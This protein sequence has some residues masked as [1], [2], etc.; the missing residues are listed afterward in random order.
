MSQRRKWSLALP[1]LN[2]REFFPRCLV[3]R[4]HGTIGRT[5][6][7]FVLTTYLWLGLLPVSIDVFC[8]SNSQH[9]AARQERGLAPLMSARRV[10]EQRGRAGGKRLAEP[11]RTDLK[12][13]VD[14]T[15]V[16]VHEVRCA[17][18]FFVR[19]SHARSSLS[20]PP[21]ERVEDYG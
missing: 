5:G 3:R 8:P 19:R 6:N 9:R 12:R 16:R 11:T 18:L 14:S 13:W 21:G 2:F 20:L 10:W 4:T 1:V 7:F 15:Y 17:V